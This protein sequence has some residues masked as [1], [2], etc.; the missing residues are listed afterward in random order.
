MS[1]HDSITTYLNE[2][3]TDYV[4]DLLKYYSE[5][6]VPTRSSLIRMLIK[7]KHKELFPEAH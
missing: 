1:Q 4:D 3:D 6:L 5:D 7:L 2:K